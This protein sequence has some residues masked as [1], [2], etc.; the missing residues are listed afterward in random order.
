MLQNSSPVVQTKV[1][2]ELNLAER[3]AKRFKFSEKS[4]ES[5]IDTRFFVPTF[6]YC[7]RLS[8]KVKNSLQDNRLSISPATL[9]EQVFL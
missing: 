3:A 8:S 5:Y 6:N 7:E 1:S 9:E 4:L 2:N